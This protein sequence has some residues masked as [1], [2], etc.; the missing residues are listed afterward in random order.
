MS[1]AWEIL[2]SE[3]YQGLTIERV[4]KQTGFSKGTIY[5]RFGSKDGLVVALGLEARTILLEV[6]RRALQI[7]GR[8]RERMAALGEAARYYAHHFPEHLRVVK[9]IE[10]ETLLSRVSESER[11]EMHQHDMDIFMLVAEIIQEALDAGDLALEP[12]ESIHGLGFTFW[13]LMDGVFGAIYGGAPLEN[14]QIHDPF[15]EIITSAQR[16]MDGYGWLPLLKQW[17]YA[18]ASARVRSHLENAPRIEN[19][20]SKAG[21]ASDA[22]PA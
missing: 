22:L 8:P 20:F 13:A 11:D 16:M 19:K 4:A 2:M 5:L 18:S 7:P 10:A 21:P 12:G 17:D 1:V 15:T 14:A 9:L 3:G 6:L